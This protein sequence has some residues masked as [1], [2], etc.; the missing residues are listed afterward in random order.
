MIMDDF[1]ISDA[2][3]IC[4]LCMFMTCNVTGWPLAG[5]A[6]ASVVVGAFAKITRRIL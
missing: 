5:I 1:T 2:M 3:I 6:F 4:G